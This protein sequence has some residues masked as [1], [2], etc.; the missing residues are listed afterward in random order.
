MLAASSVSDRTTGRSWRRKL[1]VDRHMELTCADMVRWLSN[2]TPRSR[3]ESTVVIINV[4]AGLSRTGMLTWNKVVHNVFEPN[5]YC[6]PMNERTQK[7]G[8]GEYNWSKRHSSLWYLNKWGIIW[9]VFKYSNIWYRVPTGLPK[10]NSLTFPVNHTT[11]PWPTGV[12][13]HKFQYWNC[14]IRT[15]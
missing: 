10:Q 2:V 14:T 4:T 5:F 11:F 3:A 13:R 9:K 12:Y 6:D 1:Y 7:L 15:H 8:L